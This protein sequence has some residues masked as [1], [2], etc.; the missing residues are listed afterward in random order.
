MAEGA[1]RKLYRNLSM[2]LHPDKFNGGVH[3]KFKNEFDKNPSLEQEFCGF[4]NESKALFQKINDIK[5]D[6]RKTFQERLALVKEAQQEADV[7]LKRFGDF[8]L[9]MKEYKTQYEKNKTDTSTGQ[10]TNQAK[11]ETN[12]T[13]EPKATDQTGENMSEEEKHRAQA[14]FD[15]F[16]TD[17]G[18]A[19]G[20][21]DEQQST[22]EGY[23]NTQGDAE[24]EAKTESGTKAEAEQ[25]DQG[26]KT[27]SGAEA[28]AEKTEQASGAGPEGG[29]EGVKTADSIESLREK[30]SAARKEYLEFDYKKNTA[31]NRIRKFF[32][33]DAINKEKGADRKYYETN[34]EK[35]TVDGK[36]VLNQDE[37]IAYLRAVYD[38]KLL[39]LRNKLVEDAKQRGASDKELADIYIE[40]RTTQKITLASEHD[41]VKAEQ[42]FGTKWGQVGKLVEETVKT[43]Q[44]W[45]FK[46]KMIFSGVLLAGGLAT[47]SLGGLAAAGI[48]AGLRKG[49]SGVSAGFGTKWGL[50]AMGQ[51][52][53]KE[54]I[55][56]EKEEFLKKM[57]GLSEDEKYKLL[58]ENI[59]SIAIKD[60]ENSINR[61][62]NQDVRQTVAGIGVGTFI[63][64]GMMSDLLKWGYHGVFDHFHSV[65][66]SG[67][68]S[69][70]PNLAGAEFPKPPSTG[71][72]AD[73]TDIHDKTHPISPS[74]L[75]QHAAPETKYDDV[76][77]LKEAARLNTPPHMDNLTVEKGSS[78]EGTL[79]KYL[80]AHREEFLKNH[81]EMSKFNDGQIAHRLAIDFMHAHPEMEGHLPDYI[82]SGAKLDFNPLTMEVEI[83]D[84]QGHGWYE[85]VAAHDNSV[86]ETPSA[87]QALDERDAVIG[88]IEDSKVDVQSEVENLKNYEQHLGGTNDMIHR[89]SEMMAADHGMVQSRLHELFEKANI[90]D[91]PDTK[92]SVLNIKTNIFGKATKAFMELKGEHLD[93]IMK[94]D[95]AR[96]AFIKKIP[97][98]SGRNLFDN[99]IKQFPPKS[100]DT[101]LK[102]M[103][104]VAVESQK[105]KS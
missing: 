61:I 96:E 6:A 48:I 28:G 35:V 32:N 98:V 45:S 60:E 33:K 22:Y 30:V 8:L 34:K 17:E 2:R 87:E 44:G 46:K 19:S 13:G 51:K 42:R 16:S 49:I 75:S 70:N 12:Q 86:S 31:L 29:L 64:S 68:I 102:W 15:R 89:T 37:D 38:D 36:E 67:T 43:Y 97:R 77:K 91:S 103:V 62:K 11:P 54:K 5:N 9:K 69:S 76:A 56:K 1:L 10:N 82:H 14:E 71:M 7:L 72:F 18:E 52:K 59:E 99:F 24:Q 65:A 47:G 26:P 66:G 81:P 41:N 74:D 39:D 105:L 27:E 63:G 92:T 57:E 101:T 84:P 80:D 25:A 58:S 93:E 100:G 50:E 4:Q 90:L 85:N 53:D 104:R 79:I 78:F 23:K 20:D 88:G 73:A 21:A 3:D 95:E 40:F 83:N 55:E 94:S